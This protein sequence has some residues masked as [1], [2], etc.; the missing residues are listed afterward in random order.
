MK[1]VVGLVDSYDDAQDLMNDLKDRGL[2]QDAI[3]LLRSED[4]DR[5]DRS[6]MWDRI[7]AF[8]GA[9]VP[10]EDTGYYAEG[11][12]RKGVVVS[13]DVPDDL[14]DDVA[15]IMADHGAVDIDKKASE[16]KAS[17]WSPDQQR[18]TSIPVAE[19][20]VKIG[21]REVSKGGIRVYSRVLETPVEEDISLREERAKVERR[22][23]DRPASEEA[24]EERSI[25]IEEM[26]EEPV[27]SKQARVTEEVIVGKEATQ[28]TERV[29]ETARKTRVEVERQGADYD[30]D[31][32]NHFQSFYSSPEG[33]YDT[34]SPAYQFGSTMA[35]DKRYQGK[36]WSDIEHDMQSDWENQHRGTW[37]RFKDAIH[38][39]WTRASG[40]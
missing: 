13:A 34:Y 28:R 10:D 4:M 11:M 18:G 22:H 37:R 19:E 9:D 21:K 36:D 30:Q 25:E 14:S 12:R 2:S 31:F 24:F 5:E 35:R 26:A 8:F 20:E 38:Y 7:K 15:D 23:A 27:I 16:W 32:R 39:G 3:R 1:R 33:T 17:G 6:S 29:K 40:R